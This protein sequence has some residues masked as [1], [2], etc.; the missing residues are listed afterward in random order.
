[1]NFS[2][3]KSCYVYFLEVFSTDFGLLV[4]LD[5]ARVF[6]LANQDANDFFWSSY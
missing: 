6:V 1:M 3:N 2:K 5:G 4:K